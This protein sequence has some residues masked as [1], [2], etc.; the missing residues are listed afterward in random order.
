M[1]DEKH[2]GVDR[3]LWLTEDLAYDRV[4]LHAQSV[5]GSYDLPRVKLQEAV[6]LLDPR[7]IHHV[8]DPTLDNK[9]CRCTAGIGRPRCQHK[10]SFEDIRKVRAQW[11][12]KPDP[13]GDWGR[14]LQQY[15]KIDCS[16]PEGQKVPLYSV[17]RP[18][19]TAE[20]RLTYFLPNE[21]GKQ[22]V[23]RQFFEKGLGI[24]HFIGSEIAARS[25]FQEYNRPPRH[26]RRQYNHKG[27][28]LDECITWWEIFFGEYAQSSGD[29]NRYF[30]VN[31]SLYYLYFNNFWPWWLEQHGELKDD[32]RE[33]SPNADQ[34]L[35][36]AIEV[37][38]P[39]LVSNF[40]DLLA[41]Y[42]VEPEERKEEECIEDSGFFE[43]NWGSTDTR[44]RL[45]GVPRSPLSPS[46]SPLSPPMS[47][48]SAGRAAAASAMFAAGTPPRCRSGSSSTPEPESPDEN[49]ED[50]KKEWDKFLD[51]NPDALKMP[52]G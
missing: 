21:S 7:K 30:P 27:A 6:D 43:P 29:G 47:P 44:D 5:Q 38:E 28:Q 22:P 31:V 32:I 9:N 37:V 34:E 40:N 10:F 41:R 13:I 25:K 51:D 52:V 20:R 12:T 23:C 49:W 15:N 39:V 14:E 26:N 42:D 8:L 36:E 16:P 48:I 4:R 19:P 45:G 17:Q 24:S 50:E 33:I 2:N 46:M 11:I 18:T 1:Q 35:A 3:D